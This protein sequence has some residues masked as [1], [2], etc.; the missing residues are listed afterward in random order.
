MNKERGKRETHRERE[1]REQHTFE[2]VSQLLPLV[3]VFLWDIA[4]GRVAIFL[5]VLCVY[6]R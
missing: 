2:A 4:I 1:K 6:V 5:E 3:F